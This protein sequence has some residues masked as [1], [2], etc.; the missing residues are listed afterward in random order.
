MGRTESWCK[1]TLP[2]ITILLISPSTP[3]VVS[4]TTVW[5]SRTSSSSR[6]AALDP[7]SVFSP[8]GR[9]SK[10][11]SSSS[12]TPAPRWVTDVSRPRRTKWPLWDPSKRTPRLPK[13]LLKLPYKILAFYDIGLKENKSRKKKKKKKKKKKS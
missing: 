12:S 4:P 6:D 13:L 3:W 11:S 9:P 2:P 8:R 7:R 5:S 10:R 1:T